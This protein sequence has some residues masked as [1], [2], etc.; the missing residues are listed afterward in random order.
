MSKKIKAF[1]PNE[2]I[3]DGAQFLRAEEQPTGGV[4]RGLVPNGGNTLFYFL[5]DDPEASYGR[6]GT[7]G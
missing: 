1:G 4:P 2:P 7:A 3:P 5:V 6:G